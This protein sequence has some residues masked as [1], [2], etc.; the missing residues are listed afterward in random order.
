MIIVWKAVPGSIQHIAGRWV[1]EWEH[2]LPRWLDTLTV[3]YQSTHRGSGGAETSESYRHATVYLRPAFVEEDDREQEITVVHEFLHVSMA[4]LE[5]VFERAIS[6]ERAFEY[7]TYEHAL[8][9]VVSDL[10]IRLV[11]MRRRLSA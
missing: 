7:K 3:Q 1:T 9:C 5:H 6:E 2:L 8:E 11:D 10:S 4:A